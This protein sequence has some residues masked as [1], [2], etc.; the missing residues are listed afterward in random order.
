MFSQDTRGDQRRLLGLGDDGIYADAWG[1][2]KMILDHSLFHGVWTFD[3]PDVL[4]LEYYNGV[5]IPKTN[6]ISK[7]SMLQLVSNGGDTYL[8][9]KRHPRYQPNRGHLY[10]TA[11]NLDNATMGN[12]TLYAVIRT[13]KDDAIYEDRKV[14]DLSDYP[15]Y[16]PSK[17][18]IYDIQLQWR[19]VG[20]IK[21]F[22]NHKELAHFDYLGTLDELSISN[23]ALPASY[24]CSNTGK[25]RAGVFTPQSGCFFEWVFADP[26]DTSI[27]CGCVDVTSEGG[28]DESQQFVSI[29]GKEVTISDDTILVVRIPET[30]KGQMNTRDLQLHKI[31]STTDKKGSVKVYTTRDPS[32][33]TTALP[34]IPINGGNIEALYPTSAGDITFDDSKAL[35]I[36]VL[37]VQALANNYADNP[38]PAL[39]HFFLTHGDYMILVGEGAQAT[40]RAIIQVGEEL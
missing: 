27:R 40:M 3:V 4:W 5:E 9:S 17:G 7:N 28:S 38:N 10:S 20:G 8:M 33:I 16:A 24:E 29:V 19:G 2:Q 6:A 15:T 18:N 11:F 23:P 25:I 14:V 21:F 12:G 36:D 34:W 30:F 13:F 26:Q 37:P 32:A 35:Q 39:V 1:R 31:K 22:V